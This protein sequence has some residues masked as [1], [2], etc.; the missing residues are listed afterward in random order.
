M[1]NPPGSAAASGRS[2]AL[3]EALGG[4]VSRVSTRFSGFRPP[5]S[6]RTDPT[7]FALAAIGVRLFIYDRFRYT[8]GAMRNLKDRKDDKHDN[9]L[10]QLPYEHITG[11]RTENPV[12]VYALS[13]C[14]F[15]R[16]AIEMLE[17]EG[18]E[19]SYVYLDRLDPELKRAAKDQLRARFESLPVFPVLL[20][21]EEAALSGYSENKWRQIIG[22]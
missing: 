1:D 14:A 11:R 7:A 20:V 6:N 18:I 8:M 22:I 16:K 12:T 21:G 17:Q 10:D 3:A 2:W 4:V 19:F 5:P 9:V 13:T 15:C